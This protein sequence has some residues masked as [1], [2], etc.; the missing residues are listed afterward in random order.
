MTNDPVRA[1][2][3]IT[4][5]PA[6]HFLALGALLFAIS[7]LSAAPTPA[8]GRDPIVISAERVDEIRDEYTRTMGAVPTA[9]ELA[10]LIDREAEDEM[11]YREALLLGLDRG[12]PAVEWRVIEKM[13]FLYEDAAGDNA[14]KLRRGLELG[15]QRDD[16][17]IRNGLI[18]KMRLLAKG[19]SRS[20]EPRG[21]ELERVLQAYLDRHRDDYSQPEL[22]SLTHVFLGGDATREPEALALQSKLQASATPPSEAVKHGD[23]FATGNVIRATSRAG[24]AK[25]FGVGCTE[26]ITRVAPGRWSEPIR[27]PYGFH[28]VWVSERHEAM[29][30]ELAA[31][32]SQVL[33]AYRAEQQQEYLRRMLREIRASYEVRVEARQAA[34]G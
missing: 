27:S 17:I 13:E 2:A 21:A 20:E 19:A 32:R 33:H 4:R 26:A 11:L 10:A 14:E 15:L 3:A 16:L 6:L 9:N 28:L 12:D 18:T 8:R 34:D 23:P 7:S 29:A 5:A 1:V 31:V 25:M 22:F 24:L 30:P